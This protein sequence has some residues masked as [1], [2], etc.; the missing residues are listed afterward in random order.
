MRM[1]DRYDC[2]HISTISGLPL[3]LPGRRC[4]CSG[5]PQ[6]CA[7]QFIRVR[8][9]LEKDLVISLSRCSDLVPCH[10]SVVIMLTKQSASHTFSLLIASLLRW[11]H[12]C[13]R[14][15]WWTGGC[16]VFWAPFLEPQMP[17]RSPVM[18]SSEGRQQWEVAHLC[19]GLQQ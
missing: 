18:P 7:V 12:S 19:T 11:S 9:G 4:F 14:C 1:S 6:A 15:L 10:P 8:R 2:H 17:P 5:F 13:R 16:V 3:C